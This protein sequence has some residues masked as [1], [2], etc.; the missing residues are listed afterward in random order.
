MQILK[1]DF[2]ISFET[3][4]FSHRIDNTNK[5][6]RFEPLVIKTDN[7]AI[8][9][10]VDEWSVSKDHSAWNLITMMEKKKGKA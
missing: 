3:T 7:N 5:K 1:L 10:V 8:C 4:D 6:K 9:T 2:E